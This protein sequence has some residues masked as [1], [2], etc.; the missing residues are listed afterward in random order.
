MMKGVKKCK[1]NPASRHEVG[2]QTHPRAHWSRCVFLSRVKQVT[3]RI[4]LGCFSTLLGP[5]QCFAE[6]AL[7]IGPASFQSKACAPQQSSNGTIVELVAVL[8][9]NALARLKMEA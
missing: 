5:G 3:G 8:S 9:V 7:R 1:A 6:P 4:P 2:L